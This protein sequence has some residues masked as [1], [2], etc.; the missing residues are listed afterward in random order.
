[1]HIDGGVLTY[2]FAGQFEAIP[3]LLNNISTG[4]GFSNLCH[5]LENLRSIEGVKDKINC[6]LIDCNDL[7][8]AA[9]PRPAITLAYCRRGRFV[10]LAFTQRGGLPN[11]Q[12]FCCR[13]M[14]N[15]FLPNIYHSWHLTRS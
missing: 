5:L 4:T 3:V 1:M 10:S 13:D 2:S 8:V 14:G 9:V 7:T 15:V 11:G 12:Q 6:G